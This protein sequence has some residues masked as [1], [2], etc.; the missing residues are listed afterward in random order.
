MLKNL[1]YQKFSKLWDIILPLGLGNNCQDSLHAFWEAAN[2]YGVS[3]EEENSWEISF[4]Y[5]LNIIW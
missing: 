4:S 3:V 2:A 1:E 5:E